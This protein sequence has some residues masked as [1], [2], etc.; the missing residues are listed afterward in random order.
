MLKTRNNYIVNSKGK[1]VFLRGVNLGGWLMMEGYILHGRNISEKSFKAEMSRRCGKKELDNFT[2]AFR[3]NF[4]KEAD[5][6]N[7]ARLDLNCIRLPFNHKL[8]ENQDKKFSINKD[9]IGLLKKAVSWCK[10]YGIYCILD[11]HAAPGCQN[12]DWHADSD[13]EMLLWGN[14]KFRER[15]FKLWEALA[16]NF[17]D[18]E[19]IAG[20]N[21][22]NE[23]VIKKDGKKIL[24][25]F[26]EEAVKRIR[27]I[28]DKHIIFLEGNIWSQV[29]EDIGEPFADNLSYSIHFY[30]PLEFTCNFHK[31]L[32]YPGDILGER[33]DIDTIR[34]RLKGY[35]N[36]S[37]KRGV[38][39]FAGE[40][41]VN[42][43]CGKCSGELDWVKDVLKCFKEF[44]FHWT[45][46]TYKAVG[47]SV[48]PDGVYQ[49]LANPAWV[50]RQGPVYGF[51]NYYELW[52]GH[53][54]DIIESWKT[55]NFTNNK[56]LSN[57]LASFKSI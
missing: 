42:S 16:G 3:D 30:H 5:F 52:N 21:I 48:C 38:P 53:K 8:I 50:N 29:L 31:G 32:R 15:Y 7:I 40:F 28:D 56:A 25:P 44:G 6:K 17:K 9:G 11:M 13:G 55:E 4:I 36:Y 19:S 49:Y 57:L 39:I 18:E 45:Y 23:P 33:W 41:G 43:R 47:N 10:K 14:K 12:H 2:N 46:W 20:Y 51:E 26:Y 37:K 27:A 35:Y 22:L 34:K 54:K 1:K 24:R